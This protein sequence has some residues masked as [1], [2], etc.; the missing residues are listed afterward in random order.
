MLFLKN[1]VLA[2]KINKLATSD[3]FIVSRNWTFLLSTVST[4]VNS[5]NKTYSCF[6]ISQLQI[7]TGI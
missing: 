5:Y 2:N 3:I 1:S 7:Y 6:V 4:T